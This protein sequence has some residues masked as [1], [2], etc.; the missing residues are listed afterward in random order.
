MAIYCGIGFLLHKTELIQK[1]GCRA[2]SKLLLYVILPCVIINAFSRE[3]EGG[4]AMML[5]ASFL[6]SSALLLL[7]VFVSKLLLR[8]DPVEEFAAAY[9]NVGFIG[10]SLISAT[11]GNEAIFYT[12]PYI[13]LMN[14]LQWTYGQQLL[15]GTRRK[16]VLQSLQ[17]PLVLAFAAGV[18]FYILPFDL[19]RQ[20][21]GAMKSLAACNSPLAMIIIG[22]Y[23][24][25]VS[26]K[27]VFLEKQNW[28]ISFIRLLLIP[29]L[30]ILLVM[31]LRILNVTAKL[32]IVLAVSA[33]VAVNIAIYAELLG[34]DY[35]KATGLICHST[36]LCVVSIPV[37][38][39]VAEK[40]INL[41]P[42]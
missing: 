10:I 39:A 42:G 6:T 16:S 8:R 20:I 31:G 4:A 29:V 35:K 24:A 18:L 12:A 38:I 27:Q 9:S 5:A 33:P 32:A 28:K 41:Q 13:A 23:M 2:V 40:L 17:N 1:E 3:A 30:C 19:P 14:I 11:L 21:E 22:F 25:E 7:A 36:I 37:I 34:K 15:S 26:L